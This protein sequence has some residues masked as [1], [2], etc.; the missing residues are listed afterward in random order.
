MRYFECLE[1]LKAAEGTT[2]SLI[3][4]KTQLRITNYLGQATYSTGEIPIA[5]SHQCTAEQ[6]GIRES[7]TYM[8]SDLIINNSLGVSRNV[9]WLSDYHIF[10][11]VPRTYPGPA[12]VPESLPGASD[13]L[14]RSDGWKPM[15]ACTGDILRVAFHF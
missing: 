5:W 15:I 14:G 7:H 10:G 12:T 8:S 3:Q 1:E 13:M 6:R 9:L 11:L 2:Y 4:Q